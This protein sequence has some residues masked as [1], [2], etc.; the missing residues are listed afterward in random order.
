MLIE[1]V[2]FVSFWDL[3][4]SDAIRDMDFGLTYGD[5]LTL[6]RAEDVLEEVR[7]HVDYTDADD[8]I[9]SLSDVIYNFGSDFFLGF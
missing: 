7:G 2:S 3:N 9:K 1:S 8:L 6:H 5:G 4:G